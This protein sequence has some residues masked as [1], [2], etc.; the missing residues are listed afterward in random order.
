MHLYL[1]VGPNFFIAVSLLII[2]LETVCSIAVIM[3][4]VFSNQIYKL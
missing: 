1:F 3:V 4:L 2:I